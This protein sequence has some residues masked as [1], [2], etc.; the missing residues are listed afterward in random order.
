MSVQTSESGGTRPNVMAP[1]GLGGSVQP[2]SCATEGE[3]G[4]RPAASIRQ[5]ARRARCM[6]RRYRAEAAPSGCSFHRV[7]RDKRLVLIA[8]IMGTAVVSID[9]T[10]VE[11][12]R[13]GDR[14]D[15]AG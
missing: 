11:G 4:T 12:E 1:P 2:V 6:A 9:S 13:P 7:T 15:P 8:A 3:P 10:A 5:S 14:W